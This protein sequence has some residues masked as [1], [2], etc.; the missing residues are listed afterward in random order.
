MELP[1]LLPNWKELTKKAW[2][3]RWWAVSVALSGIEGLCQSV[4]DVSLGT[5]PGFLALVGAVCG[6]IGMYARN[7]DQGIAETTKND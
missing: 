3:M 2:S 6:M 5:P 1:K 7:L 4:D